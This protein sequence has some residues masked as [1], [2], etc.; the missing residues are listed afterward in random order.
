MHSY[1]ARDLLLTIGNKVIECPT[2]YISRQHKFMA[3]ENIKIE[4]IK[5]GCEWISVPLS[6][7]NKEDFKIV[8]DKATLTDDF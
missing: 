2:P 7:M 5:D 3:F 6:A 4:A 8:G 1:S